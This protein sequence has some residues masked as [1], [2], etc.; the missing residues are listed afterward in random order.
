MKHRPIV[1]K[2]LVDLPTESNLASSLSDPFMNAIEL[3]VKTHHSK[4]QDYTTTNRPF[5]NFEEAAE[6][7]NITTAQALEVLIGTKEARRRNLEASTHHL[8]NNESLADTLLDRAVYCIIRYAHH[9]T[10]EEP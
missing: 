10:N 9:L 2:S 4:A 6:S 8:P 3:I 5:G 1:Q 7:A